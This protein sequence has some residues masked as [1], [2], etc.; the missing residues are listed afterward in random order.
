MSAYSATNTSG[1]N[2]QLISSLRVDVSMKCIA[3]NV[4]CF[5]GY[6]IDSGSCTAVLRIHQPLFLVECLASP[7]FGVLCQV[8]R[9]IMFSVYWTLRPLPKSSSKCWRHLFGTCS[10]LLSCR[11]R[12][13]VQ[14]VRWL[15]TAPFLENHFSLCSTNKSDNESSTKINQWELIAAISIRCSFIMLR[16]PSC[17]GFLLPV[18]L[19]PAFSNA[20]VVTVELGYIEFKGD[21]EIIRNISNLIYEIWQQISIQSALLN[22]NK[23]LHSPF[24]VPYCHQL[25]RSWREPSVS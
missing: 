23:T 7:P 3:R 1:K 6:I 11:G 14:E 25:W 18:N 20:V 21:R 24:K 13:V 5:L 2:W 22:L 10:S 16:F 19:Q 8:H 15:H 4:Y 12:G 9:C 17:C